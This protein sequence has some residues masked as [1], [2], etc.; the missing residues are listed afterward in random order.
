MKKV[1]ISTIY[2]GNVVPIAV[3]KLG[4]DKLI[5]LDAE[6]R[7][8][9]RERAINSLKEKYKG[10]VEVSAVKTSS[11]DIVKIAS[12][13]A[14]IIDSESAKGNSVMLHITESRKIQS[15]GA[16]FGAYLRKEKVDGIYYFI[17]ET[18]EPMKLP[19]LDLKLNETKMKM[20]KEIMKGQTNAKELASKL[21]VHL[22]LI[23]ANFKE[24]QK[25]G[26]LDD[27]LKITEAGRLRM[28]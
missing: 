12:D 11:Y 25:E 5:L 3:H 8:D 9:T 16:M 21:D 6:D 4:P 1:M 13:V 15:I 2:E 27:D 19:V 20:M 18:G 10:I 17:Q 26:L 7:K 28:V 23:Y 22:S 24:M 14:S